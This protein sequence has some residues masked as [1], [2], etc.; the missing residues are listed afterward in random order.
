MS[1]SKSHHRSCRHHHLVRQPEN[2]ARGE[3]WHALEGRMRKC[4]YYEGVYYDSIR[5]GILRE[6]WEAR[7]LSVGQGLYGTIRLHG[8]LP[9]HEALS[10]NVLYIQIRAGQEIL[11]GSLFFDR[12]VICETQFSTRLPLMNPQSLPFAASIIDRPAP[13]TRLR[14]WNTASRAPDPIH[15][16]TRYRITPADWKTDPSSVQT[17]ILQLDGTHTSQICSAPPAC[18]STLRKRRYIQRAVFFSETLDDCAGFS[19]SIVSRGTTISYW[20]P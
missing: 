8:K 12:R 18:A 13:D 19:I 20:T 5:M 14:A 3:G 17:P 10:L 7:K 15:P 11:D 2:D 16:D 1:V 4:R 9:V 6:E